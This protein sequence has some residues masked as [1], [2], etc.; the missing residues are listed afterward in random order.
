MAFT[1]TTIRELA[2]YINAENES[3]GNLQVNGRNDTQ[4]INKTLM[5][6]NK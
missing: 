5:I 3:Q 2:A 6:L 4:L 1:Y